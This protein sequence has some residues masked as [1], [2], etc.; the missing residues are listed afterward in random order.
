[1][2]GHRTQNTGRSS[3]RPMPGIR[4]L[5]LADLVALDNRLAKEFPSL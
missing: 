2:R 4:C 1:M 5:T 3:L